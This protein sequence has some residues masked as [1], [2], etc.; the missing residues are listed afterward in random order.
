MKKKLLVVFAAFLLVG[1][2]QARSYKKL[3]LEDIY[4]N[5][6]F[7]INSVHGLRWMNDG[8][9]YTSMEYNEKTYKF[10]IIKFDTRKGVAVDTIVHG[11]RLIP[12]GSDK[13][14]SIDDYQF[15][16]NEKKLLLATDKK[17]IYR[18][19]SVANYYIY[20]ISTKKL[21]PLDKGGKQSYAAF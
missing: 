17:S 4:K 7:H 19:S 9:Y 6:I 21:M 16:Q 18:R 20:D 1:N 2:I 3:T 10:D 14:I 12:E 8:S 13:S 5:R 11:D 15:D